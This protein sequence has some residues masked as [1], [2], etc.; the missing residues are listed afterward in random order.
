MIVNRVQIKCSKKG[1]NTW[2]TKC[3]FCYVSVRLP[4]LWQQSFGSRATWRG[5][6]W[7]SSPS[8]VQNPFCFVFLTCQVSVYVFMCILVVSFSSAY[9]GQ[10]QSSW[11]SQTTVRFY[12]LRLH[13]CLQG[14]L[15]HWLHEPAV[16]SETGNTLLMWS[17][18]PLSSPGVFSL[19]PTNPAHAG[20]HPE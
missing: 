7:N 18:S 2:L 16:C 19:S 9:D 10:E 13:I 3:L 5:Q 1:F 14:H 20:W 11:T 6:Y 17:N 15:S 8:Y 12:W 4:C